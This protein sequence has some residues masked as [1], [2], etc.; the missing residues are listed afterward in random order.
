MEDEESPEAILR[1]GLASVLVRYESMPKDIPEVIV[2]GTTLIAVALDAAE[3]LH[4]AYPEDR[5]Y[6]ERYERMRGER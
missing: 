3:A 2:A 1:G 4:H 6:R 5:Y